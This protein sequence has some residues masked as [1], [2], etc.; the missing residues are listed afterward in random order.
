MVK[1]NVSSARSL[2]GNLRSSLSLKRWQL[3]YYDFIINIYHVNF[4]SSVTIFKVHQ[5]R[6]ILKMLSE[7]HLAW[8]RMRRRVPRRLIRVQTV[9]IIWDYGRDRQDMVKTRRKIVYSL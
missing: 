7:C 1:E 3:I 9:C 6:L 4:I 5:S 8:I 2:H